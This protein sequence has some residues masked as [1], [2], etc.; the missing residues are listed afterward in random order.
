[1]DECVYFTMRTDKS[2]NKTKTW[3][4]KEKCPKCKNK[5]SQQ[6]KKSIKKNY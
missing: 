2:G 1:M 4:F 6:N 3:V 5:T